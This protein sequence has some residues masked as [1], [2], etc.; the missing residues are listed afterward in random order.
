MASLTNTLNLGVGSAN[1]VCSAISG[2][3]LG[4][5]P[6]RR[7]RSFTP[8]QVVNVDPGM[9]ISC[10]TDN[11]FR[12]ILFSKETFKVPSD[13]TY[14][15]CAANTSSTNLDLLTVETNFLPTTTKGNGITLSTSFQ[16][17]VLSGGGT[18]K[19]D[20]DQGYVYGAICRLS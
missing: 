6:T 19:S 15:V 18:F 12:A 2:A 13:G 14:I 3:L 16:T 10:T 7:Y 1:S 11:Y 5:G 9:V 17:F 4:V 8:D 20:K